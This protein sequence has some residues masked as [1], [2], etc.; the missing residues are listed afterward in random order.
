MGLVTAGGLAPARDFLVEAVFLLDM[1][2][3]ADDPF[4]YTDKLLAAKD[5][6]AF[7]RFDAVE[8][9]AGRRFIWFETEDAAAACCRTGSED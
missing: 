7:I 6:S 3:A 2:L 4:W 8:A 1:N 5:E 9:V